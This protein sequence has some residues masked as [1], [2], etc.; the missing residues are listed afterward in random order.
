MKIA[1][2]VLFFLCLSAAAF[3]QNAPVLTN[4]P[5]PFQMQDHPLHASEHAMAKETSLL[6]SASPYTY[7]QGEVPLAELGSPIYHVPLGDLAREA[8]KEHA[9]VRKAAKI[10]EN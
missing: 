1:I 3:S 6:S 9:N 4:L 8:R 7:A 5:Q 10:S 2:F